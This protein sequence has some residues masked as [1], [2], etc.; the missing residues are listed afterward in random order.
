MH[1]LGLASN[2][3]YLARILLPGLAAS[4]FRRFTLALAGNIHLCG[5]VPSSYPVQ[6]LTGIASY[7]GRI[8]LDYAVAKPRSPSRPEHTLII[9][10]MLNINQRRKI[11]IETAYLKTLQSTAILPRDSIQ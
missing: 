7:E 10:T 5:T 11:L 9:D 1:L 4:Y 8:F 3:V 6:Q 2:G